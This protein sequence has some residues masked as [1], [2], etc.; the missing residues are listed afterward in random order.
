MGTTIFLVLGRAGLAGSRVV[1]AL[2]AADAAAFPA[3]GVASL[4][5]ADGA[6]ESGSAI[7]SPAALAGLNDVILTVEMEVSS[8]RPDS[9][10]S[11]MS[12][13]RSST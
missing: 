4:S 7:C 1:V 5:S 6:R 12:C 2:K 8:S 11:A 13:A 9:G 3:A 10:V